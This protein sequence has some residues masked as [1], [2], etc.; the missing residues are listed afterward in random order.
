MY[1]RKSS[2]AVSLGH[3]DKIADY[4]ADSIL[5][6]LLKLDKNS[7][8]ACEVLTTTNTVIIAGEI[9]SNAKIDYKEIAK[10]AIKE[11]GYSEKT[12]GFNP[13]EIEY[14]IKINK[15]S[16]D[17]AMGVDKDEQGAGDQGIIFGY[18]TDETKEFLPLPFVLA[19]KL[20]NTLR[21]KMLNKEI[22]YILPD[23]KSQITLSENK[24]YITDVVLSVNHLDTVDIEALRKDILEK[25]I[26]PTL[27]S[28][29]ITKD[30]KY[31]INY[32][33]RFVVGGPNCDCGVTGRKLVA[34]TYGGYAHHGGGAFSGK[35]PSKLDRSAAYMARYIAKNIV[36]AK[37]AKEC[38]VMLAYV[39][40][41]NKPVTF[42]IDTFKTGKIKDEKIEK[43]ILDRLDL[44]PKGISNELNLKNPIYKKSVSEGHFFA[45]LPWEKL[46]LFIKYPLK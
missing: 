40:G 16:P 13:D 18:A 6:E 42:I 35:D 45:D 27:P 10:K 12:V 14:I 36:N 32:T 4:I 37:L 1:H 31:W 8:V 26:L 44:S 39:I 7:K 30:T 5:D 23:A 41:H 24:K 43:I 33:G 3:P 28:N 25:V 15:Q 17:I 38:E 19:K 20:L 29:M 2:E 21:E 9:T 22:S 34:D 46:D 11:I